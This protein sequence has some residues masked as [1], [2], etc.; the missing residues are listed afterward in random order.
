M[1]ALIWIISQV[2]ERA[3]F[4][5]TKSSV[6]SAEMLQWFTIP[7]VVWIAFVFSLAWSKRNR[8][9]GVLAGVST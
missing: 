6:L 5:D 3:F 8:F 2:Y 4:C 9:A 1:D 7:I